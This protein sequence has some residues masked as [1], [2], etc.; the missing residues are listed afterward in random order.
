MKV[1]DVVIAKNRED[2]LHC[3]HYIYT[4]AIVAS[5]NPFILVSELGDM[6]W[7][8]V[9]SNDYIPLCQVHPKIRKTVLKRFKRDHDSGV[10]GF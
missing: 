7:S 10:Y 5:T 9:D 4:H 2:S 8:K 6:L 1:G 3:S